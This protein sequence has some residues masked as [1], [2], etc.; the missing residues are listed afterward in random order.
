[1]LGPRSDVCGGGVML[2]PETGAWEQGAWL[3]MI[4]QFPKVTQG[5]LRG[6]GLRR[7]GVEMFCSGC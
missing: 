1:M 3:Q 5:V 6:L 2:L 4:L 7:H